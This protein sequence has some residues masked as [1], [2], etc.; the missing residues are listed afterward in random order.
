MNGD[1]QSMIRQIFAYVYSK[2]AALANACSAINIS[3]P[4]NPKAATA[5]G[6]LMGISVG[7]NATIALDGASISGNFV[8]YGDGVNVLANS[9]M[10]GS[11]LTADCNV[12][13]VFTNVRNFVDLFYSTIYPIPMP[14]VSKEKMLAEVAVCERTMQVGTSIY[15][16][17]FL[18]IIAEV[19]E[20]L[21]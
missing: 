13:N 10:F 4:A 7:G 2:E 16:S 21:F 3:F 12:A 5:K 20:R 6:T 18:Q 8:A 14:S 11:Q 1:Y 9:N 17:L 15:D 19:M